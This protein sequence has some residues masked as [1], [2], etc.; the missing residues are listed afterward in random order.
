MW[1]GSKIQIKSDEPEYAVIDGWV[2]QVIGQEIGA[3]IVLIDN[4]AS[5]LSDRVQ[6]TMYL[7]PYVCLPADAD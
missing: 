6:R 2:G 4:V 1:I 7:P 5:G 3:L